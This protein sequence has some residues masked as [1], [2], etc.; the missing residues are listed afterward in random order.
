MSSLWPAIELLGFMKKI[1]NGDGARPA[2]L[3]FRDQPAFI[4]NIMCAHCVSY[5]SIR[6]I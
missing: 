1:G 6:C 3:T 2:S 4:E 5:S